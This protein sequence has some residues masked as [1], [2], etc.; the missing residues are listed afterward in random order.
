MSDL[1]RQIGPF[2]VVRRLG[3][4]GV[5]EVLL[6]IAHGAGGFE[7]P[8]ALKVLRAELRGDP[9]YERLLLDE[10]RMAARFDHPNLVGV[11]DV[12]VSNGIYWVRMDWV[13]GADLGAL[14]GA[15]AVGEGVA[16]AVAHGVCEALAYLHGLS[17]EAGRSYGL[18]H[19]DVSPT[20]V[21][22]GRNGHVRLG[23]FGTAKATR[24]RE[25]TSAGVRKGKYAYMS[26]EQVR[27]AVLTAASDQFAVG[28]LLAEMLSGVRPFEGG[29]PLETMERIREAAAPELGG[30]PTDVAA[31]VARCLKR[32][33]AERYANT[34]ELSDA[35]GALRALR[36][37]SDAGAVGRWV[38]GRLAR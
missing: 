34:G 4:G 6:A 23:D 35:V 10:A 38:A 30:L 3:F 25:D 18:V 12:G 5:G 17:D 33:A 36:S 29:G 11:H 31:V 19:R 22:I 24:H 37:A 7:K 26:P 20:N 15:G 27:G 14:M 21:L 1:P 13:D 9:D 16:L 32:D 8:I 28:T 2:R